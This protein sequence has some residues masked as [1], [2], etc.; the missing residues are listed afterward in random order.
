MLLLGTPTNVLLDSLQVFCRFIVFFL[1]VVVGL[2]LVS[3]IF[4]SW[5]NLKVSTYLVIGSVEHLL[6]LVESELKNVDLIYYLGVH[7]E[8]CH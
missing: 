8:V 3:L 4:L 2:L 5:V 6:D 7:L 1:N